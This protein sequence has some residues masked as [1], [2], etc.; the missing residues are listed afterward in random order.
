MPT[1]WV[2]V[3]CLTS[4]THALALKSMLQYVTC[5]SSLILMKKASHCKYIK[6]LCVLHCAYEWDAKDNNKYH[7]MTLVTFQTALTCI[8]LNLSYF[9]DPMNNLG[10]IFPPLI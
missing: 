5:S 1:F 9:I 4:Q 2:K 10:C 3:V 7:K 6:P 8:L